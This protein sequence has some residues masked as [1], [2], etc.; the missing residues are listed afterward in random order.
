MRGIS[1]ICNAAL[2]PLACKHIALSSLSALYQCQLKKKTC[3]IFDIK[4]SRDYI[5]LWRT[6][7]ELFIVS[8]RDTTK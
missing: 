3:S 4:E 5:P 2:A 1:G 7:R 6:S 8:E